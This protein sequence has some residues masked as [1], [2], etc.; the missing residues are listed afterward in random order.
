M[1]IGPYS[2]LEFYDDFVAGLRPAAQAPKGVIWRR[3][4]RGRDA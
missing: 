2:L 3:S 4:R 1:G